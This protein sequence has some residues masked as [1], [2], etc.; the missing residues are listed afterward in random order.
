MEETNNLPLQQTT[1]RRF[2][3][4]DE[5]LL[6][7]YNYLGKQRFEIGI[8]NFLLAGRDCKMEIDVDGTKLRR[9]STGVI[10]REYSNR[11]CSVQVYETVS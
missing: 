6:K 1:V 4:S 11:V 8:T 5:I 10:P 9:V 2:L 3:S 7:E